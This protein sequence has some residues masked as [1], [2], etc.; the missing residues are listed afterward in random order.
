VPFTGLANFVAPA[1]L[2]PGFP[3][4]PH[5]GYLEPYVRAID[6]PDRPR[7]TVTWDGTDRLVLRSSAILD[8]LLIS[9]RVSHDYWWRAW[10]DG[11][12][13]TVRSDPMGNLLLEPRPTDRP[14]TI[15]LEFGGS[16]QQIGGTILSVLTAVV[17]LAGALREHR[18]LSQ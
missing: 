4:G 11:R 10:Q 13:V 8:G 5:A 7:I 12:P 2:P 16:W 6:H 15:R 9:L 1:E 17:C 18:R 3:V 14:A